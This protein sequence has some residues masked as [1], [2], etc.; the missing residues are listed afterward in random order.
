MGSSSVYLA[1]GS[2]LGDKAGNCRK[3]IAALTAAGDVRLVAASPFY[4]TEPV[5]FTDQDWFVNA[6][7]KVETALAPL[8]LLKR[9]QAV[10]RAAGRVRGGRRFGPRVID[11][12]ILLYGRLVRKRPP[13]C[14]PHPR[15]HLRRFVLVPMCDIDPQVVH[16]VLK[17]PMRSLLND[18]PAEGQH[19]VE[20]QCSD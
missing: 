5:D 13:L 12:D 1:V 10:E 18:L 16:P 19:V 2:N 9:L 3:A 7:V 20:L 4:R 11:L 6:V 8:E 14:I 15:M 17:Q